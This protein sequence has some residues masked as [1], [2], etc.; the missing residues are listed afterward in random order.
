MMESC[1]GQPVINYQM[2]KVGSSTVQASLEALKLD[3]PVYHVHFLNPGRV[4][5]IERQRKRYFKTEKYSYLRRPWL[6]EFLFEEIKK[7]NRQWKII[8]L[9]REPVARNISTF[10]ENLEV[11]QSSDSEKYNIKS[12]YYGFEVDIS[13]DDTGPLIELFFDRLVH[14]RPLRYFDEE[15]GTVFGF[16]VFAHKFHG[17]DGYQIIKSQ[18]ADFL[19]IRLD[20][21]DQ[22]A[23]TAFK[24]FLGVDDFDLIQTNLSGE[25]EYAPIY[26]SFKRQIK[27]PKTYLDD[28]YNSKFSNHFYSES[29][30]QAYRTL[31]TK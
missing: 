13:L 18:N 11:K 25:K 2:G 9:V 6:S 22:C 23:K 29:E 30:I 15:I 26:K 1:E 19:L 14:D 3:Y 31:W 7:N 12:D 4:K 8:T 10:F 20:Y 17:C 21:L 16:D 5:E 28:M 24:Q 27:L